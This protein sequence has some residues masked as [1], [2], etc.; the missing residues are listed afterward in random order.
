[1]RK[2]E[3]ILEDIAKELKRANDLKEKEIK[4]QC[5]ML[6]TLALNSN[7]TPYTETKLLGGTN[8]VNTKM[9]EKD[10]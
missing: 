9:Q 10:S 2:I 6:G 5:L 4:Q 3:Q 8:P 7:T 1:M